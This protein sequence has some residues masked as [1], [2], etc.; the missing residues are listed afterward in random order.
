MTSAPMIEVIHR[1]VWIPDELDPVLTW[2]P[3]TNLGAAVK[4]VLDYA[5]ANGLPWEQARELIDRITSCVVIES[6][7]LVAH[8][9]WDDHMGRFMWDEYGEVS[10]KVI[11]DAGVDRLEDSFRNAF[12]PETWNFH[13]IGTGTTAEAAAQTAL[14]TELT[15]QYAPDN[16]RATGTQSAS[17]ANVYQS[18]GT[19]TVDAAVAITEHA[20]M[21][22][23]ATGGGVMW[24]RSVFAAINL[25][26][27]DSVQTSYLATLSSGG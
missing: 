19:N 11:T 16:T 24:D 2:R 23:A 15:T 7:L 6:R 18:I 10:H 14:V 20:L 26:S 3:K 21:S 13:A 17:A 8:R 9:R 12:E 5:I 4:T 22:Q 27:G 25:A 1:G